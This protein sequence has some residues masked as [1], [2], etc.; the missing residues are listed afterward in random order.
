L[1]NTK[2]E[3]LQIL[4]E[5]VQMLEH[6]DGAKQCSLMLQTNSCT[7]SHSK[8]NT[9]VAAKKVHELHQNFAV[10]YEVNCRRH[11]GAVE[12]HHEAHDQRNRDHTWDIY[13]LSH[14]LQT[15]Q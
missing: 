13:T 12:R 8:K 7:G 3:I 4:Q 15:D 2:R 5:S 9:L 10:A 14:F 1:Q 6:A 11:Q